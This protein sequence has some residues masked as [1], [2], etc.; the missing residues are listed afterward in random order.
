MSSLDL[1]SP[2]VDIIFKKIFGDDKATCLAFICA[3]LG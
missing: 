3:V 2:V 1:L